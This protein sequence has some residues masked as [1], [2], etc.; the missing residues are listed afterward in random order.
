MRDIIG[1]KMSNNAFKGF[2][3]NCNRDVRALMFATS[4]DEDVSVTSQC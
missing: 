3:L 2:P 1:N 4:S